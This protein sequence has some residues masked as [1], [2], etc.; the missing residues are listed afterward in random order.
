MQGIDIHP[1]KTCPCCGKKAALM[2][3]SDDGRYI[4][5]PGAVVRGVTLSSYTVL[6]GGCGLQ[7]KPFRHARRAVRVW[8]VRVDPRDTKFF[9]STVDTSTAE[10]KKLK[11]SKQRKPYQ[12]TVDDVSVVRLPGR[13]GPRSRFAFCDTRTGKRLATMDVNQNMGRLVVTME[14]GYEVYKATLS[15]DGKQY[16]TETGEH[17]TVDKTVDRIVAYLTMTEPDSTERR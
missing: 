10:N 5:T 16:F 1:V 3:T 13:V 8:N 9:Y 15:D 6:C 4:G 14:D 17:A 7:T 2:G 12:I 11:Q